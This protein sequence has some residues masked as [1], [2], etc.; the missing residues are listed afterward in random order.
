MGQGDVIGIVERDD[1]ATGLGNQLI[2]DVVGALIFS[3]PI[4]AD[5]GIARQVTQSFRGGVIAAIIGDQDFDIPVGLIQ[6]RPDRISDCRFC[7]ECG[8][9]DRDQRPVRQGGKGFA[10]NE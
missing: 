3:A 9:D 7:P 1:I 2:A 4:D 10:F 8:H 5:P 6:Q